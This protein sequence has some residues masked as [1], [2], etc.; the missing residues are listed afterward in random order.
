M[1]L[2]ARILVERGIDRV[3]DLGLVS[4]FLVVHF[5]GEGRSE[6]DHFAG[7]CIDH[8][9]VLVRVGLLLAAVVLFLLGHV[10]RALTAAFGAINRPLRCPFPCQWAGS[11]ILRRAF[12]RHPQVGQRG[13][14]DGQ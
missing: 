13:L 2:Q 11:D 9:E 12:W 14:E 4:G 1:A 10:R 5:P 3:S 6:I 7:V 8:Q